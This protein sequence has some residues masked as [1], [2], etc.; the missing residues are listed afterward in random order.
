MRN[1]LINIFIFAVFQ[2]QDNNIRLVV[3][4]MIFDS[5]VHT[6]HN[7]SSNWNTQR[8]PPTHIEPNEHSSQIINSNPFIL[9]LLAC[10]FVY[11]FQCWFH[12]IRYYVAPSSLCHMLSAVDAELTEAYQESIDFSIARGSILYQFQRRELNII[13]CISQILISILFNTYY[14]PAQHKHKNIIVIIR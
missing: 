2:D 6:I 11:L 4:E 9:M 14:I 3:W 8:Y 10:L 12:H 13:N 1:N 7:K 5:G